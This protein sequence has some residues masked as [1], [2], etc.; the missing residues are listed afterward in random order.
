MLL[1]CCTTNSCYIHTVN[2]L[3]HHIFY[4]CIQY[5][6]TVIMQYELLVIEYSI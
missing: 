1:S 5:L 4:Y 3:L 2:L 6:I